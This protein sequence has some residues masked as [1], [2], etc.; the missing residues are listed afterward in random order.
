M[1][2]QARSG[3]SQGAQSELRREPA[4]ASQY[5]AAIN[6]LMDHL[7]GKASFD[8]RA[9]SGPLAATHQTG[10]S[11]LGY[12]F[13][14]DAR[15]DNGETIDKDAWCF[16][17]Q[18]RNFLN[19]QA[20]PAT[21]GTVAFSMM[22]AAPS[23]PDTTLASYAERA[24]PQWK[25]RAQSLWQV[26]AMTKV[27]GLML[28]G[29]ITLL[30]AYTYWGDS[31]LK[32]I[33][34]T[35]SELNEVSNQVQ[36]AESARAARDP[37]GGLR[38]L[39]AG[40]AASDVSVA[41]LCTN[42]ANLTETLRLNHAEMSG[43]EVFWLRPDAR[44]TEQVATASVRTLVG[45][46]L[47]LL[48]GTFGAVAFVMRRHTAQLRDR[49]LSPQAATENIGR[50]VLGTVTGVAIGFFMGSNG[51]QGGVP[52]L[53]MAIPLSAPALAFLAGYGAEYVFRLLDYLVTTVFAADR[54]STGN[55][56]DAPIT[57]PV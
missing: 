36:Q 45:V 57:R 56:P 18:Y 24:Y 31:M 11:A 23:E 10:G 28:A 27:L 2:Q 29:V 35:T 5:T 14:I 52:S 34:Q 44:V 13:E 17:I 6:V 53:P 46:V 49:L 40:G 3:E 41:L 32:S 51:V 4:A 19:A 33:G 48:M 54:K 38:P 26:L 20:F 25:S 22:V 42:L 43:W 47:P 12:F 37:S 8:F 50:L 21:A 55:P 7:S 1:D 16:L 39:C 9:D 30:G 15:V